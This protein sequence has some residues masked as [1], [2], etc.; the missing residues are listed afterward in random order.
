[1]WDLPHCVLQDCS[2][3]EGKEKQ[4]SDII[5]DKDFLEENIFPWGKWK[6]ISLNIFRGLITRS[7][8][9]REVQKADPR[10]MDLQI[11][12]MQFTFTA[13]LTRKSFWQ[14]ITQ[15][16]IVASVFKF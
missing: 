12:W 15:Y 6:K 2:K 8:P 16:F 14:G 4:N 10:S 1:M 3:K 7:M 11:I 9:N 13:K 5:Y